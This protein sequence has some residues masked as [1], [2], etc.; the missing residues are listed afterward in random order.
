MPFGWMIA[1]DIKNGRNVL[2]FSE[3]GKY[4]LT[5]QNELLGKICGMTANG[6][7][8]HWKYLI[9]HKKAKLSDSEKLMLCKWSLDNCMLKTKK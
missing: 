9:I 7:M 5:K 4:N 8:P 1:Y 6:K 2:N 3:W